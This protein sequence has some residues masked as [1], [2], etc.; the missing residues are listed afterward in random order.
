MRKIPNKQSKKKKKERKKE[1]N[2][3]KTAVP[4]TLNRSLL[5]ALTYIP[6]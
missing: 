1:R 6:V 5:G 3:I 4:Y 2:P